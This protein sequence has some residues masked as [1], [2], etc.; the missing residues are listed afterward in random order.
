MR[1]ATLIGA[2]PVTTA[3]TMLELYE[4]LDVIG[5]GSFGIIVSVFSLPYTVI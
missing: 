5:A 2:H 3:E 4:P 1:T